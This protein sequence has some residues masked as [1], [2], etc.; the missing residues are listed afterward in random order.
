ME[1]AKKNL[2]LI[3]IGGGKM[4]YAL[5]KGILDKDIFNSQKLGVI[6][7]NPA[8]REMFKKNL[9]CQVFSTD[10]KPPNASTFIIAVKPHLA[11]EILKEYQSLKDSLFISI[12]AGIT[13]T[14][15]KNILHTNRIVRVMPNTPCMLGYGM[16]VYFSLTPSDTDDKLIKSILSSV[17]VSLKVKDEKQIDAA[18]AITGSGPG[19]VFF[20]ALSFFKQA[21]VF[22]FSEEEANILV[23]QNFLGAGKMLKHFEH[24]PIIEFI[25]DVATPGGTT[26]AGINRFKA[27]KFEDITCN[28]LKDCY[29]KSLE[30]GKKP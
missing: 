10:D 29:Q 25:K 28:A 27:E 5:A 17:G 12:M 30:I 26:E 2:D 8:A 11:I 15:L 16:S 14:K 13:T 20:Y 22:G 19:F 3:I 4:G 6:E 21:L 24:K 1:T 7:P 9:N 23:R 18:T